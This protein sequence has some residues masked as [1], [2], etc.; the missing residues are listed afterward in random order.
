MCK[1]QPSETLKLQYDCAV[2]L[3]PVNPSEDR[4][5]TWRL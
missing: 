4:Y 3:L 1:G 2:I 5:F